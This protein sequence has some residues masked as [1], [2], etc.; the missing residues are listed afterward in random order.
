ELRSQTT[1]GTQGILLADLVNAP[2]EQAL[3]RLVLAPAPPIGRPLVL[4]RAQVAQ[5]LA[6]KAPELLCTNWLGAERIK[7]ARATRVLNQAGLS[8]LL[9]A[10]LQAGYVKERGE[11]ELRFNRPWSN[12]MLPDEPLSIRILEM[13]TSG[14]S[15]Y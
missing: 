13:P 9:T 6:L 2:P 4:T 12:V 14:V 11:L 15:P 10:A 8:E 1:A 7:I 5:W 3:P